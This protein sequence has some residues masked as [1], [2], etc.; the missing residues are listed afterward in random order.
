[1]QLKLKLFVPLAALALL[2]A[3]V[4]AVVPE[5]QPAPRVSMKLLNE[6]GILDFP[7]WKAYKGKVV[8]LEFWDTDCVPC[9]ANIPHMNDLEKALR[10]KPVEFISVT[11]EKE[12][13]IRKFLKKRPISGLT[14]VEGDSA[15]KAFGVRAVPQTVIIGK[16][17]T[18]LRYT[19]PD[20]LSEKALARV[21]EDGSVSE[22]R[23]II[24]TE[25]DDYKKEPEVQPLFEVSV[26]TVSQ[27]G[28]ASFGRSTGQGVVVLDF[29]RNSLPLMLAQAYGTSE[30]R[31]ET[32][33]SLP[34]QKFSFLVRAPKASESALMPMLREAIKAA[35]GA[36]VRSMKKE[37]QVLVLTYD[38]T[39][40]HTGIAPALDG[41]SWSSGS[42]YILSLGARLP[43]LIAFLENTLGIPVVDETGL[44]GPYDMKLE[45]KKGDND[46]L[47]AV[48][49][50]HFGMTLTPATR[51]IEIFEAFPAADRGGGNVSR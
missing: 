50:E 40:P 20:E 26:T 8:V 25:D 19:A 3:F 32:S 35:Y 1:M 39:V 22:I 30:I 47:A 49:K 10:G 38:K 17:G 24:F 41:D 21:L 11:P 48:L 42:G 29:N 34:Q 37:K 43:A 31:I 14:A 36:E 7:G 45:W 13:V 5:G 44:D 16:D 33:S 12:A 27:D 23:N 28:K 9:V 2:P 6:G 18:V 15:W 46:S 51:N 4:L